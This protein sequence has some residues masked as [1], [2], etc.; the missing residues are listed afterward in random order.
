MWPAMTAKTATSEKFFGCRGSRSCETMSCVW[1]TVKTTRGQESAGFLHFSHY[2]ATAARDALGS[3]VQAKNLLVP[4]GVRPNV[5]FSFSSS[6]TAAASPASVTFG[7][8]FS[9]ESPCLSLRP[10]AL[11]GGSWDVLMF[12]TLANV[13]KR[14]LAK[15]KAQNKWF[16]VI[17]RPWERE[18]VDRLSPLSDKLQRGSG[19][20]F[21][22]GS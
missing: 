10:S 7:V 17:T 22:G 4:S 11:V 6:S 21:N 15:H 12:V 19:P 1:G 8:L 13:G 9:S 14:K 2:F 5:F 16:A 18:K 3:V 20:L